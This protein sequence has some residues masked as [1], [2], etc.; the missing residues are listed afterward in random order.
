M[1]SG[2]CNCS[3]PDLYVY[4]IA[5]PGPSTIEIRE[6]TVPVPVI[7]VKEIEVRVKV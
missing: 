1:Y 2:Q 7:L 6:K 5:V 3:F 4:P